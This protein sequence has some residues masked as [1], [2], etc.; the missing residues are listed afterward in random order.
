MMRL[1]NGYMNTTLLLGKLP[2]AFT[3]CQW[4]IHIYSAIVWP[5]AELTHARSS[6]HSEDP[7]KE[8]EYWK[9]QGSQK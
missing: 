3:L 1:S 8:A 7:S 6:S 4:R 5:Q 9:I 2:Y